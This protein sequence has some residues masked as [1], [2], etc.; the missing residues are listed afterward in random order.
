MSS[1]ISVIIPNYNGE[2]L[3]K[4]N[5]PKI[6]KYFPNC[7]II[8]SDDCS[9]DNSVK[10]IKADFPEVEVTVHGKNLG[11]SSTVNDGVKLARNSILV[12]LNTDI[13]LERSYI[14][15]ITD[16][17]KE[18]NL[19]GIGF[20]DKSHE[21]NKVI[22][23]GRGIGFFEKGL[24]KHA[25][26]KNVAGRTLWISGGSCA[27]S[28]EKFK[29]LNGFNEIYNPF[30]WEDIDLSYRAIKSGWEIKFAPE[31][32]VD[33]FHEVGSIR[34]NN[35]SGRITQIATRNMFIFSAKN[36][37]DKKLLF[38]FYLNLIL[39]FIKSIFKNKST[40]AKAIIKFIFKLPKIL[41]DRKRESRQ[42][43]L[44]DSELIKIYG[45]EK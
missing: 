30:Y 35:S 11:F 31:I 45:N 38:D 28:L 27:V 42:Y 12:F 9:V 44:S 40:V 3:I 20:Q 34:Q 4:K 36:I 22:L 33:H 18:E 6:I 17:F 14:K 25:K 7:Q 16:Y 5:L 37:T 23:R 39:L 2:N 15:E 43:R 32:I 8:I 13:S 24:L 41:S 19:F 1:K 29:K 10:L 21:N 26:G